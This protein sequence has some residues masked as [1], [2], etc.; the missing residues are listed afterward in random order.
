MEK[1][2]NSSEINFKKISDM[3]LVSKSDA[4]KKYLDKYRDNGYTKDKGISTDK[5]EGVDQ[6][7]QISE[8]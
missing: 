6:E 1:K 7:I 5:I 4:A 8:K 2:E 3:K